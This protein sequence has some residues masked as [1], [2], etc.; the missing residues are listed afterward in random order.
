MRSNPNT[1][2]ENVKTRTKIKDLTRGN[3]APQQQ[4]IN[5]T[6]LQL[7]TGGRMALADCTCPNTCSPCGPDDN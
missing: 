3:Q 5:E 1:G 7:V 2:V 6:E 4:E